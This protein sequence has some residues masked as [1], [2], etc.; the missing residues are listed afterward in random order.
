MSHKNLIIAQIFANRLLGSRNLVDMRAWR[1]Y[2]DFLEQLH[3]L[4]AELFFSA[5]VLAMFNFSPY[6]FFHLSSR[7]DLIIAQVFANR[8]ARLE[9]SRRHEGL[10]KLRRL[11]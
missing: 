10:A 5:L 1:N 9:K 2:V 4:V 7:R 3:T 8:W 6:A 11:S